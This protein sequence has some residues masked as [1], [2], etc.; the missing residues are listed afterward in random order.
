MPDIVHCALQRRKRWRRKGSPAGAE[1]AQEMLTA[2]V[3]NRVFKGL[4]GRGR[5]NQLVAAAGG[6]ASPGDEAAVVHHAWGF[7]QL[8]G[9]KQLLGMH[10]LFETKQLLGM[11]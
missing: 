9:T 1:A 2:A 10:Q 4:A 6:R 5:A 11:K 3:W 7:E 8:M